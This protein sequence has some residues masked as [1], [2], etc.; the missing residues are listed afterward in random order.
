[1][2]PLQPEIPGDVYRNRK[3]FEAETVYEVTVE[4]TGLP[5]GIAIADILQSV[6]HLHR[7][8]IETYTVVQGTLELRL[9]GERRMLQTGDVA[10][11]A[12][13]VVHSAR[14][15]GARPARITVTTIPEFSAADYIV[16]DHDRPP[17]PPDA[18]AGDRISNG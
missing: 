16:A 18:E 5:F 15:I 6:P 3:E 14:S 2:D 4:A 10:R 1:M 9:D 12:P 11:I 17:A 7:V 13:G 8:T